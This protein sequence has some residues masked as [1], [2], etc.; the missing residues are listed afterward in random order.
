MPTKADAHYAKAAKGHGGLTKYEFNFYDTTFNMINIGDE[1][2]YYRGFKGHQLPWYE[3]ITSILVLVSPVAYDEVLTDGTETNCLVHLCHLFERIINHRF[4][5]YMS[6]ILFFTKTDI[7]EEKIKHS[8]IKDYFPK[9]QGDPRKMEDVQS[10]ILQMFDDTRREKSKALFHFF[11][12]ANNTEYF[13]F[14]FAVVK[15]IIL[16]K[17][18]KSFKTY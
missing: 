5:F 11:T 17:N 15:N 18:L 16:E 4:F 3:D 13:K 12:A 7:L 14:I 9:F 1:S 10:F 2:Y 6:V 8:S